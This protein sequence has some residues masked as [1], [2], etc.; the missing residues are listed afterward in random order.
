MILYSWDPG[1]YLYQHIRGLVVSRRPRRDATRVI[2]EI[3]S[4]GSVGVSKTQLMYR[5]NLSFRMA[6]YYISY[7][8]GKGH[9]YTEPSD[10]GFTTYALS[11]KGE[12]FLSLLRGIQSE[13]ADMFPSQPGLVSFMQMQTPRGRLGLQRAEF[14]AMEAEQNQVGQEPD[15][16]Q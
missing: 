10:D 14:P 1:D 4:L 2:F 11:T 8:V 15:L 7:L 5:V 12:R 9:L 16:E 3:L 6:E 13:L